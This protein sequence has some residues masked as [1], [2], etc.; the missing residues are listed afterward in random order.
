MLTVA[1]VRR[2]NRVLHLDILAATD[3]EQDDPHRPDR[4]EV[5]SKP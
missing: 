2:V 3:E 4:D 5:D 1:R